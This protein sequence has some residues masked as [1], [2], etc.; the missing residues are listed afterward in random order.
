MYQSSIYSPGFAAFLSHRQN[1]LHTFHHMSKSVNVA[2]IGAGVVGSAFLNQLKNLKSAIKFNVVYLARSSKE[3]I[4]SNDYQPVDLANYKTANAKPLLSVDDL[5]KFLKES[6]KPS[7][8]IDNTSN[9]SIAEAY[10]FNS[11]Q[12]SIFLRIVSLE[13]HFQGPGSSLR[14][15][16]LPRVHGG[17][18]L[19]YYWSFE[20]L[21]RYRR[22]G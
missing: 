3:A 12:K 8:L 7:I 13:R 18:W 21:G 19:A 6:K 14:R 11:Q 20:G 9:S 5:V 16:G 4:F 22:Q 17:C 15:L 2:I 10:Q 1:H